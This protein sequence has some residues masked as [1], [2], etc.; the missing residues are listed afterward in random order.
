MEVISVEHTAWCS[1]V[2]DHDPNWYCKCGDEKLHALWKA[3]ES[4][5]ETLTLTRLASKIDAISDQITGVES[6]VQ[7]FIHT[8]QP[9]LDDF[10]SGPIGK[11]LTVFMGGKK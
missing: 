1:A 3:Y 4:Y 6:A 7:D 11:M 10:A 2:R 9:M 8:V 5:S